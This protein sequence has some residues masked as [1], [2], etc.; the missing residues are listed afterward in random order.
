[1]ANR[2]LAGEESFTVAPSRYLGHYVAGHLAAGL[3]VRISLTTEAIGGIVARVDIPA[4]L[5]VDSR[6]AVDT[7]ES[8]PAPH[9]PGPGA[10]A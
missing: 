9:R 10:Q 3:G 2:R 4:A 7:Y 8:A 6:T 1:M 5:I